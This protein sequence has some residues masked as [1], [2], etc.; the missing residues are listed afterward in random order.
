MTFLM[1]IVPWIQ[2]GMSGQ[3]RRNT[4]CKPGRISVLKG[5]LTD[6]K[7]LA[8]GPYS[9]LFNLRTSTSVLWQMSG[10]D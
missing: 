3:T 7:G 5:I 4:K 2:N 8:S 9:V 6:G 10:A 1:Q